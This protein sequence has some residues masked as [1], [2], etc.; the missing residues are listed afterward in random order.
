MPKGHR[1]EDHR[2]GGDYVLVVKDNQEHLLEDIQETVER[3]L[4]GEFPT[5]AGCDIHHR[6]RA[7]SPGVRS[8]VVI[9][10]GRHT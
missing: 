8:Y 10:S 2:R 9:Q 7:R 6:A 1:Q 5:H 3:A 4:D